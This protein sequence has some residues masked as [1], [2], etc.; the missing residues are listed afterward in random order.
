MTSFR[1]LSTPLVGRRSRTALLLA[2]ALAVGAAGP[3]GDAHA[4]RVQ[5]GDHIVAVVGQELVTANEVTRRIELVRQEARA[6]GQQ[7]PPDAELRRGVIDALIDERIVLG[8]ARDYGMRV[9]DAELD[10]AVQTIATRNNLTLPQLREQLKKEGLDFNRFRG[11]IRD[12]LLVERVREREVSQRIKVSDAQVDELVAK[13]RGASAPGE[14]EYNVAQI[15]VSVPEGADEATVA[16][17]RAKA[18]AALARVRGRESFAVVAKETSDDEQRDAGG[19]IGLR[20]A[21]RLPDT[22]VEAVRRLR[23]GEVAPAV[24]RTGAGFHVL[25]LVE[26]RE[27]QDTSVTNTRA[28]HI[29]IRPGAQASQDVVTRQMLE[30]KRQI[31]SGAR[32]F[33]DLAKQH[34]QDGSAEQGGDLGFAPPGSY[35][36][37]FEVAM[38][39][40]KVGAVSNPVPTRFG[41]HL[42]QVV[43]RKETTVTAK[44]LREQARNAL[45]EQRFEQAYTEWLDEL[46]ARAYV[47]RRDAPAS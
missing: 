33:E 38:N 44:Q 39:A 18:E 27:A 30:F 3:F 5:A 29:L 19:E 41:I 28:R 9:D 37:E 32:R 14:A 42:I 46:R 40:L 10:R 2:A 47:E 22:F 4:Q 23:V 25:K 20:P 12:Q 35:V 26:K 24:L 34:S 16:S 8:F 13:Q 7:V 15:R 43:D 11:Q 36:P 31:E 21:S 1:S 6:N 17:H 45:R